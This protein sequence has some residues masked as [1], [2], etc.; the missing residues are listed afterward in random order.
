MARTSKHTTTIVLAATVLG[1]ST[2][3]WWSSRQVPDS[4]RE[5][6]RDK[7]L[8][9]LRREN[10]VRVEVAG[11][12]GYTVAKDNG[13]WALVIGQHRYEAD[14]PE[15][16][17]V[18]TEAE[19]A[20]PTRRLGA[21]DAGARERFG[22]VNPRARVTLREARNVN[23]T[24]AVGGLVANEQ[25]AYVEVDGQGYVVSKTFADAFVRRANELRDRALSSL[26][27][28]RLGRLEIDGG[29]NGHRIF[30]QTQST[31]RLTTPA[32]G[33]VGRVR[34]ESLLHDLRDMRA[35]R[36][37]ADVADPAALARAGLDHPV[38]TVTATRQAGGPPA[39]FRFGGPCEGYGDEIAIARNDSMSIACV[40]RA[41]LENLDRPAAEMRDDKL[42]WARADEVER[43]RIHAP[44][45]DFTVRRDHGDWRLEGASGQIDNDAVDA[46]L[47][48]LGTFAAETRLAPTEAAAHGL[49]PASYWIEIS[50][51]GVDGAERIN[52]GVADAD[53]MYASREGESPVL[54]LDP[55]AQ[56]N[57]RIDAARFRSR[58]IVRDVPDELAA[59][60]T[61]GPGFHDEASRVDGV[62]RLTR[63]LDALADPTVVRAAA[64][65]IATFDA[66]RWVSLA[67]LPA[68]GLAS[69]R[70]RVIARFEGA[71]ADTGPRDGGGDAGRPRVREYNIA[72][73][74]PAAGGGAYAT[75]SGRDGVFVIPQLGIDEITQ[76]HLDRNVLEV[77]RDAV[78]RIE[79]THAGG[80][81]IAIR[82][83][84]EVWRTDAGAPVERTRANAL[85]DHLTLVRAP[86]MFGYGAPPADAQIGRVILAVTVRRAGADGGVAERVERLSLG[87][88]VGSG[89]EAVSYA[90]RDGV[91]ATLSVPQ[92]VA[93]AIDGFAP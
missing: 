32:E 30:E 12:E 71:G 22:L 66:D 52:V 21:L 37:I 35:T 63:P 23:I 92:D 57:L 64:Q 5:E 75:I 20:S 17:R 74:A 3:L 14:E 83:D 88:N 78:T 6:R 15:V 50:R 47:A 51:T 55:A 90:R 60:I 67:P 19:F 84:G 48:S 18:L 11:P 10:I 9:S 79:I 34:M 68:H 16:E 49:A 69:P 86:R 28:S 26:E 8:P 72:I 38:L 62:W 61:D 77:D 93:A 58:E 44:T 25:S 31:W 45:G 7:L 13:H 1:L 43:V 29:P 87:A 65:R 39:I 56:D 24:F 81:R 80:A 4:V 82:R 53:R 73:G 59:L 70:Y 41:I 36:F 76:A 2:A 89:G 33:R 46:W 42:M 85:L 54:G 91:D 40:G 27:P